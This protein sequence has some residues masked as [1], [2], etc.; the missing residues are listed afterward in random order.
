MFLGVTLCLFGVL[1]LKGPLQTLGWNIGT[2]SRNLLIGAGLVTTLSWAG[3]WFVTRSFFREWK[4]AAFCAALLIG[5]M[6]FY[7]LLPVFS[8]TTPPI[9]WGYPR[10]VEGF[11]HLVS[12]GQWEPLSPTGNFYRLLL[13]WKMY[14]S[15]AAA[16]LGLYLV[17]AAIPF[18]FIKKTPA[19]LRRWLIGCLAF[20]FLTTLL[21]LVALNVPDY[22]DQLVRPFF[23]PTHLV[24]LLLAG[25]GLMLFA[26][27]IAKPI[28]AKS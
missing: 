3:S 26:A 12:R 7:F 6:S 19:V 13:E 18:V 25:C 14:W 4:A 24:L 27:T 22:S 15:F 11:F 2:S 1:A 16:D 23:A 5:G 17:P 20:W 10:T 21:M 28:S 8:M 9:N